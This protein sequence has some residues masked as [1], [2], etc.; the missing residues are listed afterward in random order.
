KNQRLYL[1]YASTW[2]MRHEVWEAMSA[3][4][5]Q[6]FNP[7]SSHGPGRQAHRSLELARARISKLI[8]CPR[9]GI[10][11]TGGGTQSD[12]LAI[13]GFAR[14]HAGESPRIFVSEIEHKACIASAEQAAAE[15]AR[16]FEVPVDPS[17]TVNLSW[18]ERELATDQK[19]PTLVSIMWANNEIGTVQ[20]MSE[21]VNIAHAHNA[22]VHTDAVQALSKV[23]VN[24][25]ETPVDLFSATAHKLGGPVGIGIL[26]CRPGIRLEP[27]SYGGDQERSMWPG[28][29]NPLGAIGFATAL[30]LALEGQAEHVAHWKE[31][32]DHLESR[33]L[34]EIPKARIHGHDAKQRLPHIVSVGIPKCDSGAILVS[35]DLEGIAVS[36]GSACGSDS[37]LGSNV[38][39]ALGLNVEPPYATIRF[40]FGSETSLF[41][42]N[43][44]ADALVRIAGRVHALSV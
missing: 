9:A 42:I 38:I 37:G 7:A 14:A 30:S 19:A 6:S 18:L 28:T 25:E 32:R 36:G 33:V 17:G 10:Y 39:D 41:D 12:N 8:G 3:E 15:K 40:S 31:L 43:R 13:L 23:K 24:I 1:D 16:V 27:L 44:A 29:Q 20:P 26:Y 4:L 35:L 21:I 22:V 5:A 34:S 11:F 2:P